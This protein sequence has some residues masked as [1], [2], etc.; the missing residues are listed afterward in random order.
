M[1]RTNLKQQLMKQ[2]LIQQELREK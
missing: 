2:Q 1:S